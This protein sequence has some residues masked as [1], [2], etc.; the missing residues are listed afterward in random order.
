[1]TVDI[2]PYH[3]IVR[4]TVTHENLADGDALAA[5][6]AGS[7]AVCANLKSLLETG[8]VLPRAPYMETGIHGCAPP[9][10]PATIPAPD[11]TGRGHR[12]GRPMSAP[13]GCRSGPGRFV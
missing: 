11:V 4:L 1:M 13:A 10:W 2:E 12:A 6:S 3:E 5:V 9:R 8:H 7:P